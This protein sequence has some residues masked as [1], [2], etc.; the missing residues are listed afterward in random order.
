MVKRI[1]NDDLDLG[2]LPAEAELAEDPDRERLAAPAVHVVTTTAS[3]GQREREQAAVTAHSARE[4][5]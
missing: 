3:E 4:S 1:R 5:S 2:R